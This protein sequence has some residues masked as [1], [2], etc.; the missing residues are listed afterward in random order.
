M[1]KTST[2]EII[3]AAL[4]QDFEALKAS[5]SSSDSLEVRD[6]DGRTALHQCAIDGWDRGIQFLV[7]QGADLDAQDKMGQTPLH[8]ASSEFHLSCA[9]ILLET[10]AAVDLMDSNGN[11]PLSDAIF[12]SRG[13]PEMVKLLCK[14]GAD[15]DKENS[16]GVSPRSLSKS[17]ANFDVDFFG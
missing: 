11:T 6:Q 5:H 4:K 2:P 17:I 14:F 3:Q 15:P 16:Y 12:Q 9:K 13:R 8:Y 7:E 10:G 1:A